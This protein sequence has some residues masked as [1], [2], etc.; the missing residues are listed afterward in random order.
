MHQTP[1]FD[2][3]GHTN[4][5][6]TP[7]GEEDRGV[8]ARV[9]VVVWGGRSAGRY[10][11]VQLDNWPNHRNPETHIN[12]QQVNLVNHSEENCSYQPNLRTASLFFYFFYR[13]GGDW[14]FLVQTG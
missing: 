5:V 7:W 10:F 12:V 2:R 14:S 6:C 11:I 3:D 13:V 8:G 4:L 1:Q 9:M